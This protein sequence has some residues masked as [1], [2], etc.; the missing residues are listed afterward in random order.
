MDS[1]IPRLTPYFA[2]T[3]SIDLAFVLSADLTSTAVAVLFLR[4]KKSISSLPFRSK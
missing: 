2:N 3:A 4:M 1:L